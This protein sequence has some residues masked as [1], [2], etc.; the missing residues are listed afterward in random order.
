MGMER[1]RER[2]TGMEKGGWWNEAVEYMD[3][4]VAAGTRCSPTRYGRQAS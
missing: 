1:K 4:V 2:E 3:L